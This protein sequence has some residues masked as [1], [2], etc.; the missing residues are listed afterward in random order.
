MFVRNK[1]NSDM[2]NEKKTKVR[3]QSKLTKLQVIGDL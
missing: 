2:K 1:K 3:K